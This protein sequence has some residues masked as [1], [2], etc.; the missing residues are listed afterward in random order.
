MFYILKYE[1]GA[2]KTLSFDPYQ[3]WDWVLG[4]RV[5]QTFSYSRARELV[6]LHG[7]W[8]KPIN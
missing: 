2:E 8:I 3:G 1:N 7:G 4:R 6:R 5:R